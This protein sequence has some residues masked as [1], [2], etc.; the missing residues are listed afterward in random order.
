MTDLAALEAAPTG[1]HLLVIF[2]PTAGGRRRRRLK[3]VLQALE[4]LGCRVT[5]RRTG[6]RGDAEAFARTAGAA[7]PP[8]DLVV[9]AGGDGTINEVIN[10]LACP[11][12]V[13]APP[14]LALL[15]IG[16]ANVLANEIGLPG[17]VDSLAREIA[18]GRARPIPLARANG[19]CFAMMAGV[20]F[21]AHV[22]A[23]LDP[24]LKRWLGKG[25]YVVESLRQ[26]VRFGFPRYRV[27]IDGRS[28][29]AASAIVARGRFY[30]GRFV[31]APEAR[32]G[33]AELHV[34]LFE[35]GGR[36]AV[37]LFGAALVLGLL[38]RLP[39]YRVVRGRRVVIEGPPGDPV[40]GDGD[41][42]ARL[43]VTVAL[44]DR[45]LALVVPEGMTPRR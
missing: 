38:P 3:A 28:F 10:G 19:R 16:T 8:V 18:A 32:L 14:P 13:A 6:A 45:A 26:I 24:R 41:I 33:A 40:Q 25:A 20:G 17:G 1:R 2:N 4:R 39:G 29:E 15:P 22:V 5:L 21:D 12:A 23:D 35:R 37:P 30:G 34:C 7:E 44:D 9:A 42:I 43:P 27:T 36:L 31:C 11:S